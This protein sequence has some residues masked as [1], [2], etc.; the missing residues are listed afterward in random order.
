MRP[1]FSLGTLNNEDFLSV[2]GGRRGNQSPFVAWKRGDLRFGMAS[3]ADGQGF[4]ERMRITSAGNVGIG[5]EDAKATLTVNGNLSVSSYRIKLGLEQNGGG[6]LVISNTPGDNKIFLEALS[7]DGTSHASEIL[8]TG[9]NSEPVPQL[10]IIANTTRLVG[11][12]AVDSTLTVD[13]NIGIRQN[14]LYV[15]GNKGWSSLTYNA[16]HN[17]T[18]NTWIFPD[19]SRPAVTIEMDDN[20]EKRRFEVWSTTAGAPT[21]W[22]RLL[23]LDCNT[24]NLYVKGSFIQGVSVRVLQRQL[25]WAWGAG[26]ANVRAAPGV[27]GWRPIRHVGGWRCGQHWR[28]ECHRRHGHGAERWSD[29]QSYWLLRGWGALGTCPLGLW[30]RLQAAGR[31]CQAWCRA[32]WAICGQA[33]AHR[34]LQAMV[35]RATSGF[36]YGRAQCMPA[37]FSRLST[38]TLLALSTLPLPMG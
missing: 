10:S 24:G 12:L 31:R 35:R 27:F 29:R 4:V 25:L 33:S 3:S 36:T 6:R 20:G 30:A 13:N 22:V 17:P 14:Y 16:H 15:S 23:A 11:S 28:G 32:C 37:P 1:F 34:S 38:T 18:N 8:L 2:F 5:T 26:P 21:A 7:T 9:R 19:A